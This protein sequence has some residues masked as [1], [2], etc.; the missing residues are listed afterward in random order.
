[1]CCVCVCVCVYL[2]LYWYAIQNQNCC[3]RNYSKIILNISAYISPIRLRYIAGDLAGA[4]VRVS[5]WGKTSDSKYKFLNI[6][7]FNL[8]NFTYQSDCFKG[9]ESHGLQKTFWS[10]W[11][12]SIYPWHAE[13]KECPRLY[14]SVIW[15]SQLV[16]YI[17]FKIITSWIKFINFAP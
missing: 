17:Y 7:Q 9:E 15:T 10:L 16:L 11:I 4:R 6:L 1:M 5:G 2:T 12:P 14:S 3:K 8:K 13:C